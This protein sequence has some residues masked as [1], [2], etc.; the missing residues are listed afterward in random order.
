MKDASAPA[1]DLY[2]FFPSEALATRRAVRLRPLPSGPL[3]ARAS[4]IGGLPVWPMTEPWPTR[5]SRKGLDVENFVSVIQLR[6]DEYPEISFPENTEFFQVLWA[7]RLYD[8]APQPLVRWIPD[9]T[10]TLLSEVPVPND[11]EPGTVLRPCSLHP[12]RIDDHPC[13]LVLTSSLDLEEGLD[14]IQQDHELG[15]AITDAACAPGSKVGGHPYWLQEPDVPTC[16]CRR[17]MTLLVTLSGSEFEGATTRWDYSGGDPI[18]SMH[19]PV[20]GWIT[21]LEIGDCGYLYFFYCTVCPSRPVRMIA[22]SG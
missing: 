11:P 21:G 13:W 1:V 6:R 22:Q 20:P 4:K 19:D 9:P 3:S 8:I 14:L 16:S 15:G 10:E 17:P 12:E 18:E 7:P 2:K 5:S